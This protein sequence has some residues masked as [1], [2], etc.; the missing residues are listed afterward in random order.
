MAKTYANTYLFNQYH[1]YEKKMYEFIMVADRIDTKSDKFED[2]LYDFKR[3]NIGNN[4]LKII[5]SDNVILATRPGISLPKAFKVFVAKDVKEDKNKMK[6]FIDVSDCITFKNGIYT[7]NKLEW[8]T[9][10]VIS[11][12]TSYV[13]AMSEN[14]LVGNASVLKDGG[15]AFAKCFSYIIDRMYKITT[16]PQMRNK[17]EYTAAIYYQVNILG[18]SLDKSY[19]SIKANAIRISDIEPK[20]A[21]IVDMMLEEKDF[22]NIDTFSQAIGRIFSFKDLKTAN[23]IAMWM[24]AFGTGTIFGMEFFP[25]FSTMLTNTYIGGY[26]DQQMTIEK[27]TGISMVSFSKTILQIGASV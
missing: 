17:V 19:D 6:V 27:I 4:L 3:R 12:M 22:I 20:S 11:A 13:Y 16:V 24:Q 10:Y 7:C 26:L 5:T 23:V 8:L 18:K 9:S 1:E 15:T 25:A 21:Q 14:K 2:L